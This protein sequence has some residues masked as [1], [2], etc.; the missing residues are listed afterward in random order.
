MIGLVFSNEGRIVVQQ[1]LGLDVDGVW[2]A[3]ALDPVVQGAAAPAAAEVGEDG[4]V[5]GRVGGVQPRRV[6]SHGAGVRVDGGLIPLELAHME[7]RVDL[8]PVIQVKPV[9]QAVVV[10]LTDRVRS[11]PSIVQLRV[12]RQGIGPSVHEHE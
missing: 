2:S 5:H 4:R 6:G 10:Y 7:N 8:A 12:V 1:S 3:E 9:G 11:A